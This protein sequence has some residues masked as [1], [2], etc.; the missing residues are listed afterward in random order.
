MNESLEMLG[1]GS[2]HRDANESE[3]HL[4]QDDKQTLE[5]KSL[6]DDPNESLRAEGLTIQ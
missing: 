6:L 1:D 2:M 4:L 3:L 5:P